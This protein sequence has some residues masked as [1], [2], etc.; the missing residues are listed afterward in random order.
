[1]FVSAALGLI[2]YGVV[3]LTDGNVTSTSSA[4]MKIGAAGLVVCYVF[5]LGW[6]ILSWRL[7]RQSRSPAYEMGT[8]VCLPS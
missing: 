3:E 8:K 6:A 2:I 1:M 7:R 5:L 4:L